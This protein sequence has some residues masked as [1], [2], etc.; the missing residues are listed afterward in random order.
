MW[1]NSKWV[2]MEMATEEKPEERKWCSFKSNT[3]KRHKSQLGQ[4]ENT[5]DTTKKQAKVMQ[6]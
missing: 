1:R 5:Q 6:W 4:S 3:N 2:Y